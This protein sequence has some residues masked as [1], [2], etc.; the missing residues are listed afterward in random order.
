MFKVSNN[1]KQTY[2]YDK[3]GVSFSL[4]FTFPMKE[5]YNFGALLSK[6]DEFETFKESIVSA[7]KSLVGWEGIVDENNVPLEFSEENQKNIFDQVTD[8][9]GVLTDIIKLMSGMTGKN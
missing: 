3:E 5:D 1:K 6:K 8:F 2:N 9:E 7:R 4:H